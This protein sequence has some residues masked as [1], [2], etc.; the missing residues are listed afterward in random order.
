M[1]SSGVSPQNLPFGFAKRYGVFIQYHSGAAPIL[2][3]QAKLSAIAYAEV[4]RFVGANI[5]CRQLDQR[6][7]D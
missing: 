3:H 1:S 7:F 6:E 5:G 4:R 2:C